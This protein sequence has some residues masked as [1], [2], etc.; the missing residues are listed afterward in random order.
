MP[1]D[2][3]SLSLLFGD[4]WV[5]KETRSRVV[6]SCLQG[7]VPRGEYV[8]YH[9]PAPVVAFDG[10][11][12]HVHR[13]VV[14]FRGFNVGTVY[15]GNE[16]VTLDGHYSIALGKQHYFPPPPGGWQRMQE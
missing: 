5:Y 13:W 15:D 6:A 8:K 2:S 9:V 11:R 12:W 4:D 3:Y 14:V 1:R 7:F 10:M 16:T